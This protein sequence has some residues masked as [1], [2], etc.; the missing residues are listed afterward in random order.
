MGCLLNF[1]RLNEKE[2]ENFNKIITNDIKDSFEFSKK[3]L[4]GK[5]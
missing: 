4:T 2:K 5:Y 3:R 1:I